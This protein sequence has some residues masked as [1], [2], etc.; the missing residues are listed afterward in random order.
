MTAFFEPPREGINAFTCPNCNAYTQQSWF[1]LFSTPTDQLNNYNPLPVNNFMLVEC[2]VCRNKSVWMKDM[3]Q[4]AQFPMTEWKIVWP[5]PVPQEYT[6]V[7]GMPEAVLG[8]Y[9]E[10]S[11]IAHL[12]PSAA[13]ALLRKAL[14]VLL[15][16]T[17]DDDKIK[18][19]DAIAK[20]FQNGLIGDKEKMIADIVRI[21]GNSAIHPGQI[22]SMD[23]Q[24]ILPSLFDFINI[25]TDKL[26]IEPQRLNELYE[27]LP[28]GQREAI[29]RRDAQS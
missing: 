7:D 12:S 9:E 27:S 24:E 2:F 11:S 6:P 20:L 4:S 3:V 17:L 15:R 13:A 18:P 23:S 25:L 1:A 5:E 14:E 21:S 16:L 10:A 26:I 8:I 22:N 29:E 28:T 19:N